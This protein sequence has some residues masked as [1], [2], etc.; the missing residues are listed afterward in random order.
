MLKIPTMAWNSPLSAKLPDIS[1]L[2]FPL[3]LLEVFRVVVDVGAPVGASGNVQSRVSTM[4][5]VHPGAT[6][7]GALQNKNKNKNKNKKKKKKNSLGA[8]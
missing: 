6:A 2:Q 1:R 4:A 5:A 8:V 3:S 7:S